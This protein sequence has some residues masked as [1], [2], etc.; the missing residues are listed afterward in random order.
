VQDARRTARQARELDNTR[1]VLVAVSSRAHEIDVELSDL[2]ASVE[3]IAAATIELLDRNARDFDHSPRALPTLVPFE[4]SG[5]APVSFEGIAVI[6]PGMTPKAELP[7]SAAKLAHVERWLRDAVVESLPVADRAGTAASQNAALVAGRSG[8]L[9]AF[10][11][12]EDGTFAQFPAREVSAD[13]RKRPWYSMA[14]REPGLHWTHPVVDAT[15]RTLRISAVLGLRSHGSLVGVA[16]SDLRVSS[17]AKRLTLGLAGFRRAYL[18]SEDGRIAVSDTLERSVLPRVTNPDQVLDLPSVD[19]PG[20][21]AKLAGP[22]RGGYLESG[23]R[24]LVFAKLVSP[25]W[26]YVAELEKAPY[27][28]H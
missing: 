26:T 25:P 22:E 27:A 24:L 11:G 5:G 23:D 14:A 17:L 28:Q 20:L 18:V 6:W 7:D 15:K 16:G 4:P 3:A 21:A 10:V 8:L 19:D 1:R 12:L 2:A 13:P 9:R